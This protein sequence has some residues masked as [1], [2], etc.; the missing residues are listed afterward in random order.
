VLDTY[1]AAPAAA[2]FDLG[3]VPFGSPGD[4]Q[5]RFTV[6]GKN[7]GATDFDLALD[8]VRITPVACSPTVSDLPDQTI[9]LNSVL[10]AR[11]F[12]AEDDTA[13]G[14][15]QVTATSSNTALLPDTAL[16][17]DGASP[18]Y[19]I[20]AMPAA[21]QL[22]TTAISVTADDGTTSFTE[23]FTLTVT[24]T[25][26]QSWRQQYFGSA[27]NSAAGADTANPDGDAFTNTEEYVL[28]TVPTTSTPD[29]LQS[30]RAGSNIELTFQALRAEAPNYGALTRYYDLETTTDLIN[31][32]SWQP[33]GGYADIVGNNQTVTVVLPAGGTHRFYR[34]HVRL[35]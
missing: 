1:A 17:L 31:P 18:Y 33:V 7:A 29:L 2:V 11:L 10:P 19:T 27:A 13:Q 32:A 3:T 14:S 16:V 22:G 35:Q 20:A 26:L 30:T 6:T 5:F 34:L 25:P 4:W 24:G 8:Y 23:N 9:A 28:G 15:L 12:L 21:D